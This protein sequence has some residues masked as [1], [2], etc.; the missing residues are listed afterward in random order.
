MKRSLFIRIWWTGLTE[1]KNKWTCVIFFPLVL[2]FILHSWTLV[3]FFFL[4][5][6]VVHDVFEC[7]LCL[8]F[9]F[10]FFFPLQLVQKFLCKCVLSKCSYNGRFVG[11]SVFTAWKRELEPMKN[12]YPWKH[13]CLF[14][15]LYGVFITTS[16]QHWSKVRYLFFFPLSEPDTVQHQ[17]AYRDLAE[18]RRKCR[19]Y[20]WE[21]TGSSFDLYLTCEPLRSS[22]AGRR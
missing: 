21:E 10:F 12:T 16:W 9:F 20:Y 4:F 11:A 5:I 6:P 7:S 8:F 1:I 17:W 19:I 15:G 3:F 13:L 14:R 18:F 22:S 2:L